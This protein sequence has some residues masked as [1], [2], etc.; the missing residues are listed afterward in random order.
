MTTLTQAELLEFLPVQ[1]VALDQPDWGHSS[2]TTIIHQIR[3]SHMKAVQHH[4]HIHYRAWM[5][6]QKLI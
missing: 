4:F 2:S 1:I 5:K 3:H 6:Q